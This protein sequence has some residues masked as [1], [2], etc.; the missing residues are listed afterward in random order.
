MLFGYAGV[1]DLFQSSLDI[2][3][4]FF[5]LLALILSNFRISVPQFVMLLLSFGIISIA[6]I[7][8]GELIS[9]IYFIF[10][11]IKFFIIHALLKNKLLNLNALIVMV[12]YAFVLCALISI[13]Q[14]F[15]YN[16]YDTYLNH[17][18][19]SKVKIYTFLSVDN[20]DFT[21]SGFYRQTISFAFLS[22]VLLYDAILNQKIIKQ[23]FYISAIIFT[24]S[25]TVLLIVMLLYWPR[26]RRWQ[27]FVFSILMVAMLFAWSQSGRYSQGIEVVMMGLEA[28]RLGILK[29]IPD[30]IFN[31]NLIDILFGMSSSDNVLKGLE[32][33]ID[34]PL[35]IL[36][37][38]YSFTAISDVFWTALILQVGVI[39]SL[40]I[41]AFYYISFKV[42]ALRDKYN[43]RFLFILVLALS[44]GSHLRD[45]LFILFVLMLCTYR[46]EEKK[47]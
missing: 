15:F 27:L 17:N 41:L 34:L 1:Y 44:T 10:P 37:D 16:I 24:G 5:A 28:T 11:I 36:W 29:M 12:N 13:C 25:L 23:I 38:D 33:I 20:Y 8:K 31:A 32:K 6:H 7:T 46:V 2:L 21:V 26:S 3:V 30:F 9:L 4:I 14:Y 40:V 18:N 43:L 35:I 47:I 39:G 19:F 45:S 42:I 22:I